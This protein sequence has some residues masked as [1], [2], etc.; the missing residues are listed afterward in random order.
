MITLAAL[1]DLP[2]VGFTGALA[3]IFEHSSWVAEAAATQR[4]FVS[5]DALHAAMVAVV[6][7]APSERGLALLR[8][9]PE[10][11][12]G[13]KLTAASAAEQGGKGLD[14]LSG[15][16][17]KLMAERNAAYRD[18][19]GFPFII[20]V[21]GQRDIEMILDSLAT[22][23]AN[24]PDQEFRI[25]LAEVAKIARFRLQDMVDEKNER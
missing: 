9:H 1:N 21:R 19:F 11:S 17:A 14:R 18:K 22:R 6:A 25:A 16:R 10:L 7:A 4:P 23:L 5:V 8:A 20:A 13:G 15:D 2:A 12:A 24:P 3:E